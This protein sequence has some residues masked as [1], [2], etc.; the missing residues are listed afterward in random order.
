MAGLG[1]DFKIPL[2][3]TRK[4]SMGDEIARQVQPKLINWLLIC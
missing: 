1:T 3:V 2:A 4:Y